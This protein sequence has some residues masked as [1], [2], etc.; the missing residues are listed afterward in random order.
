MAQQTGKKKN[1][2]VFLNESI[3]SFY[4][5][6]PKMFCGLSATRLHE[7]QGV[8]VGGVTISLVGTQCYSTFLTFIMQ[9]AHNDLMI[10][11]V[12]KPLQSVTHTHMHAHTFQPLLSATKTHEYSC[13]TVMSSAYI[14]VYIYFLSFRSC[15]F[16]MYCV[17]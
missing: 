4:H 14:Y 9:G 6:V 7:K 12:Y 16:V 1:A 2:L 10:Y 11:N 15:F 13:N 5:H 3:Y 8:G 17:L